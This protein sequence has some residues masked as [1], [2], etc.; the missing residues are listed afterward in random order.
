MQ[1]MNALLMQ[2]KCAE[3]RH[4]CFEPDDLGEAKS[5]EQMKDACP[6]RWL[7]TLDA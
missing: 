1:H 6:A 5:D 4:Q 7:G 2:A 3:R